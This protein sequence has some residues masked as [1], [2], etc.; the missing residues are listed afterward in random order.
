MPSLLIFGNCA[1][2]AGR[3]AET[4]SYAD[5]RVDNEVGFADD[6]GNC[7]DGTFFGAKAAAFAFIRIDGIDSKVFADMCGAFFILD[8]CKIFVSPGKTG[9]GKQ[10]ICNIGCGCICYV[11]TGFC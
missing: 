4:A 2:L 9:N 6:T 3:N 11:V 5:I 10:N 8:M 1:E 7:T